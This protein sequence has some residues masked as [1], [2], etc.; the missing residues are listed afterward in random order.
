MK[1]LKTFQELDEVKKSKKASEELSL[2]QYKK[3]LPDEDNDSYDN[4]C[5]FFTKVEKLAKSNSSAFKSLMKKICDYEKKDG[6]GEDFKESF[7][8]YYP[9]FD[10]STFPKVAAEA[11]KNGWGSDS[12]E[13]K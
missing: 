13:T 9:A 5:D 12:E 10:G 4:I 11:E 1:N 2:S 7:L 6:L 8:D 3:A